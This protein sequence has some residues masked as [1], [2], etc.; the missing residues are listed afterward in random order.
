MAIVVVLLPRFNF[1]LLQR[2]QTGHIYSTYHK[3]QTVALFLVND[4]TLG[5]GQGGGGSN[6][7]RSRDITRAAASAAVS[8]MLF[9]KLQLAASGVSMTTD[10]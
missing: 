3:P 8:A 9:R 7:S 4:S 5:F 2:P 1:S 6:S 10:K